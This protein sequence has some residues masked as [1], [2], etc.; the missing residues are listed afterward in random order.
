[1]YLTAFALQCW[2]GK[3]VLR[4]AAEYAEKKNPRHRS[5][6]SG[7]AWTAFQELFG[8]DSRATTSSPSPPQEERV[9]ER[10]PLA[11]IYAYVRIASYSE[12]LSHAHLAHIFTCIPFAEYEEKK[13]PRQRALQTGQAW[14]A[15]QVLC[16]HLQ[17]PRAATS[18]PSP[19]QE[20][21]A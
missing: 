12:I 2:L 20:E 19:P 13:N 11:C 3:L 17:T 15:F 4:A 9:G 7:H 6:Q 21:R 5:L 10:R 14:T 18:S 8:Q 16:S 1:F